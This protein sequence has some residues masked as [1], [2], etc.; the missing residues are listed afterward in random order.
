MLPC[1]C[2]LS[3]IKSFVSC[4]S[5]LFPTGQPVRS[6]WCMQDIKRSDR[7]DPNYRQSLAVSPKTVFRIIGKEHLSISEALP[8]LLD[9]LGLTLRYTL[10]KLAHAIYR[11]F[12][13]QLKKVKIS[14]E[15][16]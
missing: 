1:I 2:G 5:E 4:I 10:G 15:K 3:V 8:V 14:L 7:F 16:F 11:D 13:F 9:K 6:N 12:F